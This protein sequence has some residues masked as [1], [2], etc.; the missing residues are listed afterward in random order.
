[1]LQESAIFFLGSFLTRRKHK[2]HHVHETPIGIWLARLSENI[3]HYEKRSIIPDCAPTVFQ[4]PRGVLVVPAVNDLLENI[5]VR[6]FRNLL[7]EISA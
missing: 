2:H 5:S 4:N 7:E 3:S 6:P 1:M